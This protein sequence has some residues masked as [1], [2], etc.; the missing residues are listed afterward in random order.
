MQ[1]FCSLA[2]RAVTGIRR[3]VA[4]GSLAVSLPAIN[5]L[6]DAEIDELEALQRQTGSGGNG[7]LC[8]ADSA[9]DLDIHLL[10]R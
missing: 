5:F 8:P 10:K 1:T 6:S 9:N 2:A 3:Q 4:A 7:A